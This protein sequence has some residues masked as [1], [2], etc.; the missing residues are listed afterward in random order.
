MQHHHNSPLTILRRIAAGAFTA[1]LFL[2]AASATAQYE[3]YGSIA[4]ARGKI[5]TD[6]QQALSAPSVSGVS[7][8]R[9]TSSGRMVKVLVLGYGTADPDLANLRRAI[10]A[11]GGSVYYRYISVTGVSAAS[12]WTEMNR[13]AFSRR[14]SRITA[15]PSTPGIL[16]SVINRS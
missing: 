14:A 5:S 10:V 16:R 3:S 7:W 1:F 13:S 6:L 12:A 11:A 4:D 2:F 15:R 9:E 8:A